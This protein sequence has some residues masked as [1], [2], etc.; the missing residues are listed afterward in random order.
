MLVIIFFPPKNSDAVVVGILLHAF[1]R[2]MSKVLSFTI[3]NGTYMC[4]TTIRI[5][6]VSIKTYLGFFY[7]LNNEMPCSRSSLYAYH[8]M[9]DCQ[10][11]SFLIIS[12]RP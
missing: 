4:V 2:Q 7:K 3:S 10:Q 12:T 6:D 5:V 1:R 8:L 11:E 9:F